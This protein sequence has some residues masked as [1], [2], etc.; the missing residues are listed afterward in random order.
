[1][2]DF[3]LQSSPQHFW[4]AIVAASLTGA[5]CF[6]IAFRWLH[7]ARLIADTPTAKIRSAAQGYAELEGRARLMEGEPIHAPLSGAPCVWYSYK[8]EKRGSD[9][10]D[11]R[12]TTGWQTIESGVSEAIFHLEDDTGRCIV[13]PDHAEVT[14]SVRLRW[15]GRLARPGYAP[16]QT[17]FWDLLFSSG[18]YRYTEYRI[19]ADDPIYAIGQFVSLDGADSISFD[20]EVGD[21]LS[22]WKRNRSELIR[23]FDANGDG[24][25]DA[26]EWETVRQHA[27]RE[28]MASWRERT[29]QAEFF[30][31]K[32]PS[33]GRPYILSAIPQEKL[34]GRYRRNAWLAVLGFLIAGSATS[35]ALHLRFGSVL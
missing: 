17:G 1:M 5:A 31:M 30:L 20:T 33:H 24:E 21:L 35:W 18:P 32:K 9:D 22:R 27:E 15:R 29:R 11:G 10:E 34:T 19:Q 28:V 2:R 16:P 13:D 14:P 12:S 25:I 7:R 8:V 23:R 26:E 3:V 6:C 4:L